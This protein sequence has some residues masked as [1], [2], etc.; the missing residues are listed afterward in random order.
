MMLKAKYKL[1]KSIQLSANLFSVDI[2]WNRIFLNWRDPQMT[3]KVVY[4]HVKV[5]R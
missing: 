4:I 3:L 2:I 1:K 5:I